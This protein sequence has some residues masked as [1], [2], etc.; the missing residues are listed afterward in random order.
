MDLPLVKHQSID[1]SS[2]TPNK[3][4]DVI[5]SFTLSY[6]RGVISVGF[7]IRQLP[8]RE[9]DSTS[10]DDMHSDRTKIENGRCLLGTVDTLIPDAAGFPASRPSN[11]IF[12]ITSFIPYSAQAAER[13]QRGSQYAPSTQPYLQSI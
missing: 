4:R 1:K 10:D 13:V 6:K 2:L 7:L 12:S 9:C 5:S 8:G 3:L 11:R